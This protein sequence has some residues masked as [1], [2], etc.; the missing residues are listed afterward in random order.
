MIEI[1]TT[2]NF[3]ELNRALRLLG[4]RQLPFA[5]ALAATKTAQHIRKTLLGEMAD[6]FDR[7]TPQTLKSLYLKGGTKA[8]PEARVWF[9][10]DFNTGI[11]SDKYLGPQVIGGARRPKRLEVALRK[12]GILGGDEWAIPSKDILNNYGNM[13]GALAIRILSGLGAAE[14]TAGVTANASGSRRS[15]KKGNARRYFVAKIKNTRA[16]WE[17]KNSAFGRG[18]RPVIIFVKKSPSYKPMFPFFTIAEKVVAETYTAE[19]I[20]AID[21]AVATA[22]PRK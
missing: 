14:T 10:D 20:K 13:P 1:K 3:Q 19:F 16:V 18:I 4:E 17:V 2:S 5:L 22:R 9:K 11:P 21:Y 15:R 8:K 6:T 12:R 7:P